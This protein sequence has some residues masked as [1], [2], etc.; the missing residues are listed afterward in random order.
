MRHVVDTPVLFSWHRNALESP[1]LRLPPEIRNRIYA[2]VLTVGQIHVRYRPWRMRTTKG[3]DNK[4][5]AKAH[6]HSGFYAVALGVDQDAWRATT[7]TT[8][9]TADTKKAT[10]RA[11]VTALPDALTP[12]AAVCRQLYRDT[13]SL[14]FALN[15]WSFESARLMER[16]LVREKRLALYQRRAIAVLVVSVSDDLPSRAMEKYLGGLRAVV[17]RD[18][19]T[20]QR[21]ELASAAELQRLVA[22][23]Q[24]AALSRSRGQLH[25]Y[26]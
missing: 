6:S 12:L 21:W 4:A 11:R 22:G 2:L 26:E 14:P 5:N 15:A 18:G 24:R 19:K 23:T 17:W 9:T 10:S 13:A 3:G 25:L 20:M 1:F 8:T 16:F 7:T